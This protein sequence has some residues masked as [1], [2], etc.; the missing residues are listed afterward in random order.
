M[1]L[2]LST[3]VEE[4]FVAPLASGP[5]DWFGAFAV[6][7]GVGLDDL[8]DRFEAEHDDYRAILARALADR[9]AEAMAEA[10]HKRARQDW[11][12]GSCEEL[13]NEQL[14]KEKYR[15][16]RPAP[17]YPAQP[18]H[19]EKPTLWE[20]LG[21]EQH[22]GITLTE[23]LAMYPAASVCGLYLAHPEASYF[24]L[25][26]ISPDQVADYAQRKGLTQAEAERWLASRLNYDPAPV[27]EAAV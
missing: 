10:L 4:D 3:K 11:G 23:S 15:G 2:S 21:A 18:D 1:A 14:I 24:N 22:T 13:T 20:L 16:I 5:V 6:T 27:E 7:A 19:T 9:L 8:V 26:Q 17:G 25:G 12:Y